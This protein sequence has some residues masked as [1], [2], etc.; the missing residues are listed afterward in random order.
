MSLWLSLNVINFGIML[1]FSKMALISCFVLYG[2]IAEV[3]C[4]SYF[5]ANRNVHIQ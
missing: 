4:C 1:M 5:I 3:G 2:L